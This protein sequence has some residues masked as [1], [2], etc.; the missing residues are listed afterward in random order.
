VMQSREALAPL[1][2][3]HCPSLQAHDKPRRQSL[4]APACLL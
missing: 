2:V 4:Q 1:S 3:K